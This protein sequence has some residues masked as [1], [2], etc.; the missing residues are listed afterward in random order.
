MVRLTAAL[1]LAAVLALPARAAAEPAPS[2]AI[3]VS[4]ATAA[5]AGWN[6]VVQALAARHPGAATITYSQSVAEA[7]AALRVAQPRFVCVVA[8][9]AEAGRECVADLQRMLRAL[10]DD[11][12]TDA[13]WGIVTGRDASNARAIADTREPLV[14]R[15]VLSGTPIPLDRCEAGE[16]Y[17]ELEAGAVERKAPGEAPVRGQGPADST[18]AIAAGL[19]ERNADLFITSGHATERDWQIGYRYRSGQFRCEGG[20]VYGLDTKGARIPVDSDHARVYLPVGNCLMG[21]VDGPDCM[22]IAYMNSVGVRQMVGYTVP[23]WFGYAGWGM[24]DYFLN[25]PGRYCLSE[26]FIANQHALDYRAAHLPADHADQRGLAFDRTVVAFYGDPAWDA[27]MAD[28]PLNWKQ[29]LTREGSRFILEITPRADAQTFA[30]IDANGSQRG[31]R[32]IV[33]FLPERFAERQ[34]VE[35]AEWDPVAA[36]DFI[37][38]P[39]P[40][41]VPAKPMRIVV[42]TA[43]GHHVRSG[44]AAPGADAI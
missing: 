41:T 26:A 33:A 31:G 13:R 8:R 34:V 4:A 32:P 39:L 27:R 22:A 15:R 43:G 5:D 37:L 2:Y 23:T 9:P 36:D 17:S 25:Q 18:A 40:A 14:I 1:L 6:G 10:D 11:P 30:T 44:E 20:H 3:L 19:T 28:G 38:V 12:Y 16:W 24:L 21:H 7:A 29:T 35:G 42:E